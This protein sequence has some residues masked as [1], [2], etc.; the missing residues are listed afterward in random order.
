MPLSRWSSTSGQT[1]SGNLQP[2]ENVDP[3]PLDLSPSIRESSPV[4]S[5]IQNGAVFLHWKS[6]T[7]V[8]VVFGEDYGFMRGLLF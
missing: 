4:W 5:R 6:K 8:G 1:T 3:V 2:P 7:I